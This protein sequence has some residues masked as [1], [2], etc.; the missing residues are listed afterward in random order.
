MTYLT[1]E[2]VAFFHKNGYLHIP[3]FWDAETVQRLKS[4]MSSLVRSADLSELK[5]IFTTKDSTRNSDDYFLNS[6]YAIRYFWEEKAWNENKEFIATDPAQAINKVGHGLH[7]LA[8]DFQTVSY[9]DR[10]GS[11]CEDLSIIRP[12]V[13]QS[14]Y[15]FKQPRIGG[16]VSAHQ[17][18]SF[19]YTEPQSCLGFWWALDDCTLANGCLWAVPGSQEIG[20]SRHFR[21]RDPPLEG[22]EYRPAEATEFDLTGSVPLETPAGSLVVLHGALVHHS[23]AN[24]SDLPRHAYSIHVIDGRDGVVYP[25]DNWL[26][27]PEDHPFNEITSRCP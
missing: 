2:Q 7:D 8:P 1:A 12:L 18:G 19:L 9:A 17:D 21:R 27:R 16:D 26:Q 23:A 25:K 20:V 15:I 3:G 11:I 24:L 10:V 4:S 5:S 6:G 22:T 14:M 13:A